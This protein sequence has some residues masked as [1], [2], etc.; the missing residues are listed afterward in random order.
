[1]L[2]RST[3]KLALTDAGKTYLASCRQI[4]EAVEEAESAAAGE[5]T[6][7]RGK[8]IVTAPIVLGRLHVLP[9]TLDFLSVYPEVDVQLVLGDHLLD[10]LEEHIDLAVRIGE[11]PDSSN[12][13]TRV[14]TIRQVVCASPQYLARKGMPAKPHDLTKRECITV[15]GLMMPDVW[16]FKNGRGIESIPVHSRLVVNTAEAAIDAAIAGAGLVN[17]LSYQV[18]SAVKAGEL[19]IV[20]EKFEPDPI[21]VSLM[22]NGNRML[23]LKLRA[24]LDFAAPRLRQRLEAERGAKRQK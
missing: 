5:Y 11:L 24:F 23:P 1:L 19:S 2:N 4:L 6:S 7:P 22:F 9:V 13:A 16:V 17:A 14:G 12:I 3:R 15:S 8:L 20:L 10:L 18:E 21:P